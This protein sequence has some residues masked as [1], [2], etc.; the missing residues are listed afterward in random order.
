MEARA[1]EGFTSPSQV[2]PKFAVDDIVSVQP[3]TW[4]GINKE[5]GVGR[6]TAVYV[7]GDS[8]QYDITY[9]FGTRDKR[10]DEDFV[11]LRVDSS[12]ARP[13]RSTETTDYSELNIDNDGND[14][15]SLSN[16]KRKGGT[17][18]RGQAA[19]SQKKKGGN[20]S[21]SSR[22]KMKKI[23]KKKAQNNSL[24]AGPRKTRTSKLL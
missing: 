9:L 10:V 19:A 17:A 8:V 6:V 12:T 23:P 20:N 21:S 4:P 2:S 13:S 1:L 15:S 18:D 24:N 3:R 5:G 11:S 22:T 14:I 16:K 7:G